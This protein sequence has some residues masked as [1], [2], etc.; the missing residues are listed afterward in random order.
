MADVTQH[1]R[2]DGLTQRI[3]GALT[4]AG[5]DLRAAGR[6]ALAGV[7]EFHLGGHRATVEVAAAVDAGPSDHIVDLGCG[8]GGAARHLAD[9]TACRVTGIDLTPEFVTT[10]TDLTEVLGMTERVDFRVGSATDIPAEDATFD[11]ATLLHVGMNIVDKTRLTTEVARVLRPGGRFVVYDI[12]RVGPGDIAYPVPW[13]A[14]REWSFVEG[15]TAYVAALERAGFEVDSTRNM[16]ELVLETLATA[17]EVG[18]PPATL[19]T[20]MGPDFPTMIGNLIPLLHQSTLAP[21]LITAELR[22]NAHRS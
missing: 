17:R 11:V 5:I 7:D 15:P 2:S 6:G 8:I 3:L 14:S 13:A 22:P 18:P 1:Y 10:A 12:M 9:A 21:V 4:D 16:T 19:G 20:L